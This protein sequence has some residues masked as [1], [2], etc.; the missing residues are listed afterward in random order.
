MCMSRAIPLCGSS[1]VRQPQAVC[2]TEILHA[3]GCWQRLNTS[4]CS[5]RCLLFSC[6]RAFL[7]LVGDGTVLRERSS[8]VPF[9]WEVGV[10]WLSSSPSSSIEPQLL[11]PLKYLVPR[12]L[13]PPL[14]APRW[15]AG[16]PV[17][18][19]LPRWNR[20]L[21]ILAGARLL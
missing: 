18:S 20:W 3:R 16:A 6:L 8:D 14:A 19:P 15:A 7:P 21:L 13:W 9:L 5:L 2:A 10:A 12:V 1:A 17:M 11:F 4:L